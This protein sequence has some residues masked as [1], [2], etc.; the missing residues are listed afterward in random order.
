MVLLTPVLIRVPEL[1]RYVSWWKRQ[2]IHPQLA[3]T[4]IYPYSQRI[5]HM[6]VLKDFKSWLVVNREVATYLVISP[7]LAVANRKFRLFEPHACSNDIPQMD[8]AIQYTWRQEPPGTVEREG[9]QEHWLEIDCLTTCFHSSSPATSTSVHF[10]WPQH[11]NDLGKFKSDYVGLSSKQD[12]LSN[13]V[14]THYSPPAG[15]R[16]DVHWK[17]RAFAYWLAMR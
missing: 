3:S 4:G 5:H 14:D 10:F 9:G 7:V 2:S 16:L 6:P 15:R 1:D 11:G 8:E 12:A 13:W 17:Q